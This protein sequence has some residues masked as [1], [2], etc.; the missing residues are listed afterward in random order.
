MLCGSSNL[1]PT[2]SFFHIFIC[3][4]LF[5][6]FL[7]GYGSGYVV[8]HGHSFFNS[9]VCMM[10]KD[11]D[12]EEELFRLLHKVR[13]NQFERGNDVYD[14]DFSVIYEMLYGKFP[15]VIRRMGSNDKEGLVWV[16]M[17][18]T[19][20]IH[21]ATN[22]L[23]EEHCIPFFELK[24][25]MGIDF[26]FNEPNNETNLYMVYPARYGMCVI[27]SFVTTGQV[28]HVMTLRVYA[29]DSVSCDD[30]CDTVMS[31]I[32]PKYIIKKHE[33]NTY[34]YLYS[35]SDGNLLKRKFT[36]DKVYEDSNFLDCYNDDLPYGRIVDILKSDKPALLMFSGKPGTGKTTLIK[37]LINELSDDMDFIYADAS[38]LGNVSSESV[39]STLMDSKGSVFIFE[40]CEKILRSRSSDGQNDA[41]NTML[42]LTDGFLGDTIRLKFICTYNCD[43]SKVDDA[44]LRKGRLSLRYR[45][46]LL[47][48]EKVSKFLPGNN[49]PMA[50]ADI[51]N[52]EDNG[53]EDNRKRIGFAR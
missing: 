12:K 5:L 6:C 8:K 44:L 22:R 11:K 7:G 29:V 3:F 37:R 20:D 28:M 2:T 49:S 18:S 39:V 32:D 40:D 10:T 14:Y 50:L 52:R 9:L 21:C 46:D 53:G 25:R 35:D 41:M 1:S 36:F 31:F 16:D 4:Y 24:E 17:T 42:N 15:S 23:I 26:F 30:I 13:L 19:E 34:W 47:S 51:F 38:L 43:D 27:S 45:F 33:K 48:A